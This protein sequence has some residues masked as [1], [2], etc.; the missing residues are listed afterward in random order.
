MPFKARHPRTRRPKKVIDAGREA[1]ESSEVLLG[2]G[3]EHV[4]FVAMAAPP[5]AAQA[6]ELLRALLREGRKFS[7][8]NVREYVKRRTIEGFQENRNVT[9]PAVLGAAYADGL[10]QLEIAKRQSVV[11]NLYAPQIKSIMDLKI[12]KPSHA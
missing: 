4:K 8:Y 11:Y 5:S 12:T 9:D 6:K 3:A 2:F 10:K 7:N 1:R